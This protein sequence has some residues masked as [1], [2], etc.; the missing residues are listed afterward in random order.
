MHTIVFEQASQVLTHTPLGPVSAASFVFEDLGV[1]L[2]DANRVIAS[3]AITPPTW[4]LTT[5]ATAG[6]TQRNGARVSVSS[7]TDAS[8]GARAVIIGADGSRELFEIAALSSGAYVQ[9]V[10]SLA[11]T[12]ASGSTVRGVTLSASVPDVFAANEER[13]KQQHALRVTWTYT[14]DGVVHRVPELVQW[15]RHTGKADALVGEAKVWMSKA[16]PDAA[17]R[18]PDGTKLD[19]LLACMLDEVTDD[20]VNLTIAPESFLMGDRGRSLLVARLLMHLGDLGY[21]P[22]NTEQVMWADRMRRL[23]TTRLES[24]T[25]GL[26]GGNTAHTDRSN[27]TAE[28]NPDNTYRMFVHNL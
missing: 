9:A 7:T 27:D 21:S 8:I 25:V 5:T 28:S 2:E 17:T 3:G 26:A 15:T 16:Y 14:L 20:L 4:S 22:G 24:L 11:G 13:F 23:Y 6:P 12:Y 1:G 19:M 10:A 18:L